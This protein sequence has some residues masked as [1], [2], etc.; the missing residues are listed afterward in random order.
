MKKKTQR[1]KL[2]NPDEHEFLGSINLLL[3][4]NCQNNISNFKDIYGSFTKE[5]RP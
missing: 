3:M 5:T 1:A 2:N 4:I